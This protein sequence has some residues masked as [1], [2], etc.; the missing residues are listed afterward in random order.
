MSE[1]ITRRSYLKKVALITTAPC[2]GL[3]LPKDALANGSALTAG[4]VN[5]KFLEIQGKYSV[6]DE[7]SPEDYEF[8]QMH[9]NPFNA[10]QSRLADTIYTTRYYNGHTYVLQGNCEVRGTG[11]YTWGGTL[12]TGSS[13]TTSLEKTVVLGIVA[14]S[15]ATVIANQSDSRS[16]GYGSYWF[17]GEPFGSFNGITTYYNFTYY[18]KI[19]TNDGNNITVQ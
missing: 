16:G 5:E 15:G 10:T 18:S 9:A 13:T 17:T 4:Q 7:L 14:Y 8:V 19:N 3:A 1:L 6:G 2:A 12:Q 11:I